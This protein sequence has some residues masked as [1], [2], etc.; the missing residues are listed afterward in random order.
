MRALIFDSRY[1]AYRGVIAL[2]KIVDGTLR[3]KDH[4]KLMQSNLILKSLN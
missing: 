3:V 1:D 2:V 4:I